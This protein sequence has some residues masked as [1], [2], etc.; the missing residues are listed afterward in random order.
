MQALDLP[1]LLLLFLQNPQGLPDL[2]PGQPVKGE[3]TDQ[4]PVIVTPTLKKSYTD[5]PVL[6]ETF[7]F[8]VPKSGPW[9]L[10]L[11]SYFFDAYLVLH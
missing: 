10:D 1:L 5:V 6:G 4:D 8:Q 7:T 9:H 11:R 2:Q 3:I